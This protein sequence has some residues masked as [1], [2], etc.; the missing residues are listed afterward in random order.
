MKADQFSANSS[1]KV[2]ISP[3]QDLESVKESLVATLAITK[4][5]NQL[6]Q[7]SILVQFQEI[8]GTTIKL[9]TAKSRCQSA[10]YRAPE[11]IA[12]TNNDINMT[13]DTDQRQAIVADSYTIEQLDSSLCD[14]RNLTTTSNMLTRGQTP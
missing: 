10:H 13:C 9:Q 2:F 12:Q 1:Q 6:E 14:Q 3:R 11:N 5:E 4:E 7:H 8:G